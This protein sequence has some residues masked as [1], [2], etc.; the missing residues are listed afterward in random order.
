MVRRVPARPGLR[1]PPTLR[2]APFGD[3]TEIGFNHAVGPVFRP[4]DERSRNML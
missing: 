3:D 4:A 2:G 1:L